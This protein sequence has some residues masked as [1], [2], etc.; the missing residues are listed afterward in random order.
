QSKEYVKPTAEVVQLESSVALKIVKHAS[1]QYPHTAAGPLLG[2]DLQT[3]LLK[4][5]H[6]YSYPSSSEEGTPLRIR[7]NVKYQDELVAQ[8]KEN[9]LAVQLMGWYQASNSG[10]FINESVLESLASNQLKNNNS[11]LLIHDSSKAKYGV[12]SLRAFRLTEQ[13]LKV[14]IKNDYHLETINEAELTYDTILEEIPVKIHNNHLISLYLA[15]LGQDHFNKTELLSSNS[16]KTSIIEQN[17]ENLIESVDDLG[18]F[19]YHLLK[20]RSTQPEP[21]FQDWLFTT[22]RIEYNNDDVQQQ[23]MSQFLTDSSIRP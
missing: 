15:G 20:K 17:V 5:S 3:G 2:V 4:I 9:K 22:G 14:Y 7:S 11:I 1:E 18:N 21:S 16:S 8:L 6:S 19:Y 13:F 10:K 23:I 12:L